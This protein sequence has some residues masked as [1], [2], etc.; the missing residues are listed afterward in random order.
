MTNGI[1][2]QIKKRRELYVRE[3][4]KRT[5][6]WKKE[7][8]RTSD[9]IKK[10]KRGYMEVQKDYILAEDVDRN[11]FK[12]VRNFSRLERPPLFNVCNLD[13]FKGKDDGRAGS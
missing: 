13:I 5:S 8:V 10:S 11:F 1:R 9:L 4:G 3:G 2:S 12:H 6:D 7:K